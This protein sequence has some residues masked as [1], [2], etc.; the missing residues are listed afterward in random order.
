MIEIRNV[1]HAFGERIVLDGINL[2]LGERRI[3]IVGAN[4][5]GKT[6][7]AR[8]LNGLIVPQQ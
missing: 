3:A 8:M 5:S 7:L 2:S 6:T 1:R 4:G